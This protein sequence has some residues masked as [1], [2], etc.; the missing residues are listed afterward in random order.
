MKI[1]ANSSNAKLKKTQKNR[2]NHETPPSPGEN[3][4]FSFL[5]SI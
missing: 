1:L 3:M 2:M 5:L 4:K